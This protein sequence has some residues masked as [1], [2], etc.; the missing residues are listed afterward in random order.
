MTTAIFSNDPYGPDADD[1]YYYYSDGIG[2]SFVIYCQGVC[3]GS[4]AHTVSTAGASLI[5][6][7]EDTDEAYEYQIRGANGGDFVILR[8]SGSD[9]YNVS[10]SVNTIHGIF[11][12][13]PQRLITSFLQEYVYN[14]AVAMGMPL[15][16]VKTIRF[17]DKN[18]SWHPDV[19]ETLE[20]AEAIFFAG[21]SALLI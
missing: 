9:G 19:L 6:G 5:G 13:H 7:G 14:L 8:A 3:D 4:D 11:D 15:H 18:A 12:S 2:E 17:Y 21:N 20:Q 1:D 16:S 10:I